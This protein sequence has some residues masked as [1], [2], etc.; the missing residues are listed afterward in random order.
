MNYEKQKVIIETVQPDGSFYSSTLQQDTL[1]NL[2][3]SYEVLKTKK[4]RLI[5]ELS[6]KL[7]H[8]NQ[9]YQYFTVAVSSV[10]VR[11]VGDYYNYT[12][13]SLSV[14]V[15]VTLSDKWSYFVNPQYI[16][17]SYSSRPPR[18][19]N[20][21]FIAGNEAD[22]LLVLGTGFTMNTSPNSRTTFLFAYQAQSSNMKFER[23]LPYNYSGTYLGINFNFVY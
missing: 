7:K 6:L 2:A 16:I 5:P 9:N 19:A 12:S 10:P 3:A 18:D 17:R 8:S 1:I 13:Y 11:Y 21:N 23:Y 4:V 20:N 14:P 15:S 22:N